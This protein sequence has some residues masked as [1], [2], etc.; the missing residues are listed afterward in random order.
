MIGKIEF[1]KAHHLVKLLGERTSQL[2]TFHLKSHEGGETANCR[3]YCTGQVIPPHIKVLEVDETT[4]FCWNQPREIIFLA[5]MI[6]A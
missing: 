1:G 4:N 2:V 5:Y 6:K 3:W